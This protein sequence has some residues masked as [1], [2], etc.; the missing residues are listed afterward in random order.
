MHPLQE[1]VL[2]EQLI[3]NNSRLANKEHPFLSPAKEINN[4][5][6]AQHFLTQKFQVIGEWRAE[7]LSLLTT[8][9]QVRGQ[10]RKETPFC[11]SYL[12][13]IH[14]RYPT[15]TFNSIVVVACI[16]IHKGKCFLQFCTASLNLTVLY[17]LGPGPWFFFR[18]KPLHLDEFAFLKSHPICICGRETVQQQ[19]HSSLV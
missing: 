1:E 16:H 10:E 19:T 3:H 14:P 7:P 11:D 12:A 9:I 13:I 4:S 2:T 6:T 5:V 17:T 8:R 18:C 15:K